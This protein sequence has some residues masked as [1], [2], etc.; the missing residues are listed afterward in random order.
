M[1]QNLSSYDAALKDF[2]EGPIRGIMNDKCRIW[3]YLKKG[4]KPWE[5]RQ[6]LFA[7]HVQRS[8]AI[9]FCQAGE[10]LPPTQNQVTIDSKIPRQ[11][12]WGHIGVTADVIAASKSD[13]GAFAKVVGFETK[14]MVKD[15][16]MQ[17]NR[18]AWGD[19]T[20][21]F[22]EV[23]S[24][25]AG[26]NTVTCRG[27]SDA[28]GT[29]L[30]G[31]A[32]NRYVRTGMM[33][34]IYTSA[35]AARMQGSRVTS[36]NNSNKTFVI[37]PGTGTS[38]SVGDGIYLYRP[39]GSAVNAEPMG[40][41][42]IVDDG[43]Y[44]GTLQSVNRTTYPIW[45]SQ[46]VNAGTFAAPAA[47]T[48]D[49]IQTMIDNAAEGGDAE[50]KAMWSH[51]SVR[52]QVLSLMLTD[53]RFNVAY[54]FSQGIKENQTSEDNLETTLDYNGIPFIVDR[55]CPW[56]TIFGTS[57][58]DVKTWMNEEAHWIQSGSGGIL[59]LVPNIAGLYQAQMAQFYN[60]GTDE[61]GPNSAGCIRNISATVTRV[62]NS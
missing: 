3:K 18:S 51:A 7:V 48:L 23:L 34:D 49:M 16:V 43:T 14:R 47:I 11:Q 30:N 28:Q 27:M 10:A 56:G 42:G 1:P 40:V 41:G 32:D 58:E 8:F 55:D 4:E 2:Y 44:V 12:I 50:I 62:V 60:L 33:I 6:V 31:N 46:I 13:R 29:G 26:T 5:G 54:A 59:Q 61:D 36:V 45:D 19:G 9:S 57:P 20:G 53:R 35:G 39:G 22:G 25:N 37:I 38:P 15:M 21:K 17:M 24:Y 52:R